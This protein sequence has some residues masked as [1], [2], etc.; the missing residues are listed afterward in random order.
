MLIVYGTHGSPGA[1]TTA[2]HLASLWASEGREVLLVESDPS[3]GS[4]GH[5]LGIQFT[6]GSASFV[7][8][9]LQPLSR[10]LID[11]SQDVL[12]ETL[13]VMLAPP[14]PAGARGICDAF[15]NHVDDLREISQNEMAVVIDGGRIA[16]DTMASRLTR[17]ASG[18]A[19]VSRSTTQF[20]SLSFLKDAFVGDHAS[21]GPAGLAVT[22]GKSPM[23]AD[24]WRE[25]C[26]LRFCGSIEFVADMPAFD[27]SVFLGRTKRRSRSRKWRSSLE[28]V[29]EQLYP[30]AHPSESDAVQTTR[31][32]R[33]FRAAEP[34]QPSR[35]RE[36][37]GVVRDGKSG[38]TS[39]AAEADVVPAVAVA[40]SPVPLEAH[41]SGP[42]GPP[43]PAQPYGSVR[44][45][46]L[47]PPGAQASG[48][49]GPPVPAQPYGS[50]RPPPP[51]PAFEPPSTDV[52]AP[53]A[54]PPV[55]LEQSATPLQ[56]P[57]TA[58]GP[59]QQLGDPAMAP[60]GSFRDWAVKLHG[61]GAPQSA[62]RDVTAS[63][64]G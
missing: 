18:V 17:G 41:A 2:V 60:T 64:A 63:G 1:S 42:G 25:Q 5:K 56:P 48:P 59:S 49:G 21:S 33:R 6:P 39:A 19:L 23:D 3:G 34:R 32:P 55:G 61:L 51:V 31:T 11:H 37:A 28:D 20:P 27:L 54:A 29:G 57:H 12:F 50:V 4:L 15:S 22:V 62:A 16:A 7:A 10:H 35:P 8:S 44:P 46:P 14:S 53:A 13:H 47:V 36:T 30:L 58:G 26:G 52:H 24:E 40:P 9:G 38:E 43:G 45:P